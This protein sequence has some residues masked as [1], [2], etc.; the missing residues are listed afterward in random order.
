M[1]DPA[2]EPATNSSSSRS[3]IPPPTERS[4]SSFRQVQMASAGLMSIGSYPTDRATFGDAI[5]VLYRLQFL[6]KPKAQAKQSQRQ[7]KL[8]WGQSQNGSY[9]SGRSEKLHLGFLIVWCLPAGAL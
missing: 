6:P 9:N 4:A 1:S 5:F 8:E 7:R 2:Q 3:A